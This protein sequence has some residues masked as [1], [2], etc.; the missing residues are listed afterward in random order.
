MWRRGPVQPYLG[1]EV[2]TENGPKEY[3]YN[4][5]LI[6][7]MEDYKKRK[8][9]WA[10]FN[11]VIYNQKL[12]WAYIKTLVLARIQGLFGLS[13]G[14]LSWGF[15]PVLSGPHLSPHKGSIRVSF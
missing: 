7:L 11:F 12:V 5:G 2:S 4:M 9:L 10:L 1:H 14:F 13:H 6:G 15:G 3:C 8:A